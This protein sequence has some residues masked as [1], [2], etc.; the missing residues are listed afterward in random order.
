MTGG[1]LCNF[2]GF[3]DINFLKFEEGTA[4][5]EKGLEQAIS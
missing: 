1:Q 2:G 3:I 4:P 5:W